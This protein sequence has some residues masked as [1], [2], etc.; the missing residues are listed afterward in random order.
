MS[1]EILKKLRLW[2]IEPAKHLHSLLLRGENCV[3]C[4]DCG[5]GKTYVACAVMSAL[6]L[7]TLAVVPKIAISQWEAAAKHFGDT[8]SV[9]GYEKLRTG[10]TPYGTWDNMPPTEPRERFFVCQTCQLRIDFENFR[11]C[12]AHPAGI[13]CAVE[14]RKSWN[15]GKFSFNPAVKFVIVDEIQRCSGLDSLNADMLIAAKRQ[16]LRV[17]GLSATLASSPLQFRALGYALG[18]FN[19]PRDF[20]P[21]ARAY[22]VRY[23]PQFGGL[24]WFCGADKQ[25]ETMRKIRTNII[26]ARGARVSTADIPGFPEVDIQ[27]EIYDV[28]NHEQ[29]RAA[30]DMM[31]EALA[32]VQERA[33]RYAVTE[34]IEVM[35]GH[36]RTELLKVPLALEL[37][38]DFNDKGYSVGIFVNFRQTMEELSARLKCDCII[39]GS[40]AGVKH[41]VASIEAFQSGASRIILINS[42]AGGAALS[43]PDDTGDRPRAGLVFPGYSAERLRQVFGRFPR[44]NSRSTSLYRVLLAAKTGDIKIHKALRAKLNCLDAL[45]DDDLMPENL[46]LTIAAR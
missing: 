16:N 28:D 38:N 22:G 46:Q 30:H 10:R 2:Q 9:I 21:W 42:A 35:T 17:L 33:S 41:R 45:N 5:T 27:A 24:H 6:K 37:A 19:S 32:Q 20:V 44:A 11:P 15:Y 3:D 31:A 7:P 25:L 36:Q 14:K 26:P 40:P 23:D 12:Y 8:I 18:L 13:H 34:L 43:L 39:D 1:P 29:I 4:S